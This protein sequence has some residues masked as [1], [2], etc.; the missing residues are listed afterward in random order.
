MP[1][2]GE[3]QGRLLAGARRLANEG[4]RTPLLALDSTVLETKIRELTAA[5]PRVRLH[6][7]VKANAD[8]AV[9]RTCVAQGIGFEVASAGEL[10]AVLAAGSAAGDILFSNPVKPRAQIQ[11][12]ARNGV[13]WYAL[14]SV[15]ELRKIHEVDARACCYLRIETPN[16]GS[17]WPL[18]GKF[19]ADALQSREII[20]AAVRLGADLAGIQFHVGSQCRNAENWRYGIENAHRVARTMRAAGLELRLLNLGG[21]FPVQHLRPIPPLADIGA[22]VNRGIADLPQEVR[23]IAEPGRYLVSEAACLVCR[24]TGTATRHG[25]R[26]VY[27]DAGIYHGF[28]EAIAGL[29]PRLATDRSGASSACVVAGPTCDALDVIARDVQLPNDLGE[30]DLVYALNAGAYTSEYATRFNGF[31]PPEVIA[32]VGCSG[33]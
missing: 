26:W 28:M 17:D 33:G 8:P 7:A 13:R 15:E 32:L 29:T 25:A 24:V 18:T 23:V 1:D 27:L 10:D 21:G 12:A 19:G 6:Y 16:E 2:P 31:P 9:L 3:R 14:D 30:G 22:I 4:H 11:H 5:M 20:D